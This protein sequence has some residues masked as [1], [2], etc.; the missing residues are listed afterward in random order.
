MIEIIRP[1]DLILKTDCASSIE[2]GHGGQGAGQVLGVLFFQLSGK[3]LKSGQV[4]GAK[5]YTW[6]TQITTIT[7]SSVHLVF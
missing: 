2:T 1:T 6:I 7:I 5:N 4:S 3:C